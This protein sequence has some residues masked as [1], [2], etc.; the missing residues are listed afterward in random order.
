MKKKI[1]SEGSEGRGCREF[2]ITDSIK[3]F[4]LLV[5]YITFGQAHSGVLRSC[6]SGEG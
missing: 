4:G 1:V 5:A 3:G 2:V 6:H